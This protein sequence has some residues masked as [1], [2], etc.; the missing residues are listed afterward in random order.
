VYLLFFARRRRDIKE[1]YVTIVPFKSTINNYLKID[2]NE[3]HELFNYYTNLIGNIV[4]FLPLPYF[5]FWLAGIRSFR[6][7][8]LISFILSLSVEVLQF[9]LRKGV[10]DI[11]D[12]LLNLLGT[13]I[14]FFSC[15][16]L[17]PAIET[18]RK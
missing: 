13:T 10:A 8:F 12:I 5:L 6:K 4:L 11:D 1:R 17:F 2:N 3:H 15:R 9:V 16:F 14:G 18:N 7:V